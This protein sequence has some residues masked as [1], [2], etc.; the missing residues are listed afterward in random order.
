MHN[1]K[2]HNHQ[3]VH[4]I[5]EGLEALMERRMKGTGWSN[6]NEDVGDPIFI[7]ADV[8]PIGLRRE[9]KLAVLRSRNRLPVTKSFV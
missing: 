5:D 7:G 9:D 6:L 8:K 1:C 2:S 3:S 4:N